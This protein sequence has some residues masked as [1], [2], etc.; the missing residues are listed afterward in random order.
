MNEWRFA[1]DSGWWKRISKYFR[2][3][4]VGEIDRALGNNRVAINVEMWKV[5]LNGISV[6]A[7]YCYTNSGR[8][9]PRQKRTVSVTKTFRKKLDKKGVIYMFGIVSK[10]YYSSEIIHIFEITSI[11]GIIL[12]T[13]FK[14]MYNFKFYDYN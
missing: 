14:D 11:F 2:E 4:T 10:E 5:S 8:G 6:T 3:G 1:P 12:L 7:I 9:F 13:L